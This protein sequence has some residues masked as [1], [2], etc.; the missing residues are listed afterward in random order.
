MSKINWSKDDF[1]EIH[2]NKEHISRNRKKI[3]RF[4]STKKT[5]KFNK[6]SDY[7]KRRKK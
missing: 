7:R 3:K 4:R 1:D 2:D 6:Q 5:K